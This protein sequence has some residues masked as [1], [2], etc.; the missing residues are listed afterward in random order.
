MPFWLL[1]WN[2]PPACLIW[3]T[4]GRRS[5]TPLGTTSTHFFASPDISARLASGF[6]LGD[7]QINS[8]VAL[9]QNANMGYWTPV[10][11]L[12]STVPDLAKLMRFQ[13]GYGPNSVLQPATLE[14]SFHLPVASDAD[15]L[16]GDS[17]GYSVVRNRG[18]LSGR[19]RPRRST[20]R[21]HRV[22]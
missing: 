9:R 5:L 1:R 12:F 22:L 2:G 13:M 3:H 18:R 16:Y 7:G 14:S 21:L 4:S 6:D 19:S 10:G 8:A 15:L 11:G 17:V 20:T